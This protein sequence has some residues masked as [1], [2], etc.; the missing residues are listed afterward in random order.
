MMPAP[1]PPAVMPNVVRPLSTLLPKDCPTQGDTN[2]SARACIGVRTSA[3]APAITRL[4]ITRRMVFIL[5]LPREVQATCPQ[6]LRSSLYEVEHKSVGRRQ[7]PQ[8]NGSRS[9]HPCAVPSL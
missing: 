9:L 8:L 3:A 7:C 6:S 4:L 5:L 2:P 1:I